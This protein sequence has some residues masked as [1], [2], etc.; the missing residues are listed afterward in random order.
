M[1]VCGCVCVFVGVVDRGVFCHP[2]IPTL[3]TAGKA[4]DVLLSRVVLAKDSVSIS[5]QFLLR[6]G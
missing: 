6:L 4:C 1:C 3:T 5:Q 2:S